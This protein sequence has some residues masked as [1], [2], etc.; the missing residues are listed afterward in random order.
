MMPGKRVRVLIVDDSPLFRDALREILDGDLE[1]EVVGTSVDGKQAVAD[2]ARLGPDVVTMDIHM[3]V[4]NGLDAIERIMAEH[5]TPILV[6]TSNASEKTIFQAL[7]RGALELMMKPTVWPGSRK[8]QDELRRRVKLLATIRV[9]RLRPKARPEVTAVERPPA[10]T[11]A[12]RVL[13]IAGSTGGPQALHRIL[14][15]FPAGFP[16]GV[17]AVQHIS[18]GF[19]VGLAEWLDNECAIRVRLARNGDRVAPG[20]ALIAPEGFHLRLSGKNGEVVLDDS[21]PLDGHRPS[22]TLLFRTAAHV[23]GSRA[24]GVI[25][26]GMGRDGAEGL[27][28]I[29]RYGGT[30]IA[31]DQSS[32]VVFGMPKAAIELGVVNAVLPLD[33]IPWALMRA[34]GME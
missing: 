32:S 17:V 27:R 6:L 12:G 34:V 13:A 1:V 28:D 14:S 31:Q 19:A 5:P 22:A 30:T 18:E 9:M 15:S 21:P 8:E 3:P 24:I 26:T 4:M 16:T 29:Y 10:P 25:L 20:L 33:E 11:A 2:T 23:F 7:G